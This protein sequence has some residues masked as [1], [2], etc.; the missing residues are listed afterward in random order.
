MPNAATEIAA[1]GGQVWM[2]GTHPGSPNGGI[3]QWTGNGWKR[4]PGDQQSGAA[5][6]IAVDS[7]GNPWVINSQNKIYV[8]RGKRWDLI[9]TG[10]ATEIAAGGSQ[11]WMIGT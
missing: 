9:Q 5:V 11:V 1:G 8:W 7:S 6:K 4:Q 2:I 3:Y 10:A